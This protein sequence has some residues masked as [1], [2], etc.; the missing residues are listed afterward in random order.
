ME[1]NHHAHF[2]AFA[3]ASGLIAAL[4]MVRGRTVESDL[5]LSLTGTSTGDRVLDVGCGPGATVRRAA[6]LGAQATGVDPAPVMLR[7]ARVVDRRGRGRYLQGGAEALPVGDGEV[8]VALA[9]A[10]VH[11]WPDLDGALTELRRVLAPGGRLLALERHVRPEAT[12]LAGHGWSSEQAETFAEMLR[13]AG[14]V[15]V[16][17]EEHPGSRGQDLVV[18]ARQPGDRP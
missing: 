18:R 12:G 4:S 3:G 16:V 13:H 1:P 15:D 14:F 10:T 11:H 6:G 7:V 17:I 5:A 2:P 8:D 9:V